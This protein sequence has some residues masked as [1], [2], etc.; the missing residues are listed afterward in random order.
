VTLAS[1]P[2]K[3]FEELQ[4]SAAPATKHTFEAAEE[5]AAPAGVTR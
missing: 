1:F 2:T 5:V 3:A 4:M